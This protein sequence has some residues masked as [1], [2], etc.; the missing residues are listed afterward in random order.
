M[1]ATDYN[2]ILD[3]ITKDV[4]PDE[5]SS[6][7]NF[8]KMAN[9]YSTNVFGYLERNGKIV[10]QRKDLGDVWSQFHRT[11][12]GVTLLFKNTV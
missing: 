2:E 9:K 11:H 8:K 4:F 6:K 12:S 7:S 5:C 10:L 1:K 3:Y